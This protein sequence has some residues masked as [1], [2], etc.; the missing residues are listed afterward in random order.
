[1]LTLA[2]AYFNAKYKADYMGLFVLTFLIDLGII[3]L[4]MELCKK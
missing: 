1:M 4:L 2:L 3:D